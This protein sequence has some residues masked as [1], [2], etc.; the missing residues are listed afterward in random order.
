MLPSIVL[1]VLNHM[2][3]KF[4]HQNGPKFEF[5][6]EFNQLISERSKSTCTF[7]LQAVGQ[8]HAL[9]IDEMQDTSILQWQN[10]SFV[11]GIVAGHT[12]LLLVGMNMAIYR[13]RGVK[14]NSLL[15][16]DLMMNL[17][18]L[19][20]QKFWHWETNYRSCS[21]IIKFNN[22][23][24]LHVSK[25]IHEPTYGIISSKILSKRK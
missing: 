1:W 15:V 5:H 17:E 16:W 18:I 24:F 2:N 11:E 23:L 22:E 8:I 13:W 7:Y 20:F 6:S 19:F 25:F 9:F 21:E 4:R 14:P 3:Q 10:H 12:S